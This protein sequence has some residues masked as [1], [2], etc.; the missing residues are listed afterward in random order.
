MTGLKDFLLFAALIGVGATAFM[1]LVA[2]ARKQFSGAPAPNYGMAGRWFAHLARGRFFHRSIS[3]SPAV[4]GERLIGWS[5][6][7]LVGVAFAAVLLGIWG[8]EW[9][10]HPTPGPALLVGIA[11]VAAPFLLM[12]PGMGAGIASS[13]APDPKAARIRS[14]AAHG[15]FGAGLYV[16]GWMVSRLVS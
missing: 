12:Q 2:L 8:L 3:K 16:A 1:D 4:R 10:F 14:L 5:A 13:R 7:Y 9:I 15:T 6:H 11:T